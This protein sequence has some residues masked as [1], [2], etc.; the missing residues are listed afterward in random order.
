M[1]CEVLLSLRHPLPPS[2]RTFYIFDLHGQALQAYDPQ[3]YPGRLVLF[4]AATTSPE[5]QAAWAPLGTSGVEIHVVPGDHTAM[6]AEPHFAVLATLLR[7]HLR[8]SQAAT[9]GI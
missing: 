4:L 3:S 1:L 9:A 7:E 8:K 2:L 5:M 6:L